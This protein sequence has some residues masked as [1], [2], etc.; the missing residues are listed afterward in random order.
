MPVVAKSRLATLVTEP[1]P[2]ATSKID[3]SPFFP[4]PAAVP[5]I[6]PL[7]PITICVLGVPSFADWLNV[8]WI[9]VACVFASVLRM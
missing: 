3:P 1:E 5:K 8:A 2:A 9:A 4:P 6:L 7:P